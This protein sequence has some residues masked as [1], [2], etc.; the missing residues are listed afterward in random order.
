MYTVSNTG[1][2]HQ[3]YN[4]ITKLFNDPNRK[5]RHCEANP[6]NHVWEVTNVVPEHVVA[7]QYRLAIE[8][9]LP[10]QQEIL[11]LQSHSLG[12]NLLIMDFQNKC[13]PS[14][15]VCIYKSR[16][17]KNSRNQCFCVSINQPEERGK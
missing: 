1:R 17:R 6:Q 16:M 10:G 12:S 4:Q 2:L 15:S 3:N 7:A 9:P 13:L 14:L 11:V 5:M 8:N